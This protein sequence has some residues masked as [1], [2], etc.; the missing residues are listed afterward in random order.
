MPPN[1]NLTCIYLSGSSKRLA[2]QGKHRFINRI[3]D[4]LRNHGIEVEIRHRTEAP[5]KSECFTIFRMEEP[6]KERSV[7]IRDAYHPSFQRIEHTNMRWKGSVAKSVFDSAAKR[8]EKADKFFKLWQNKLF[9]GAA[10]KPS[11]DGFV[12]VPLQ[13]KL[14]DHRSFQSMCPIDMLKQLCTFETG[15]KILYSLHPKESYS[16]PELDALAHLETKFPNLEQTQQPMPSL[17]R[18]CDY[19]VTQNSSV[20]YFANFFEKPTVLFGKIDFHHIAL[21]TSDL[22]VQTAIQAA[23]EHRPDF[24]AYVHWFWQ[25]KSIN[26][27]RKEADQKIADRLREFGWPI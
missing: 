27:R 23:L 12:Y 19:V 22:G 9:Q 24:A 6:L 15:R 14:L 26:L 25:E 16:A 3:S 21:N 18:S 20:G 1:P 17:L 7:C 13:G 2:E 11:R 10:V 4:V 5:I 8:S